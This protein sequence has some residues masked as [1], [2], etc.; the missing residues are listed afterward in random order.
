MSGLFQRVLSKSAQVWFSIRYRGFRK[1]GKKARMFPPFRVDGIGAIELGDGSSLQKGAWLYCVAVEGGPASLRIGRGCDFGYNNHITAVRSV[2][3]G[4]YVLTANNVYI[5]DNAHGYEDVS[6]P[7]MHQPVIFKRAVSIGD[8]TWI[9]EN[10]CVIGASVGR[11]CVIGANSVV[12]HDI[13]DYCVAVGAPARI[14]RRFDV[15]LGA[16]IDALNVR[17]EKID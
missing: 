13:P 17:Q 7:I 10:A 6:R 9:G 8:G 4:D 5:S 2:A 15:T 12:L 11:N 1:L 3:I 14:V 16:W